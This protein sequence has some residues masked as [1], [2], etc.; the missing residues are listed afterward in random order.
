MGRKIDFL[1]LAFAFVIAFLLLL[2]LLSDGDEDQIINQASKFYGSLKRILQWSF[3]EKTVVGTVA[4][5][6]MYSANACCQNHCCDKYTET[7]CC[8]IYPQFLEE[9][10]S[11][12]S[13]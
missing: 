4:D 2:F 6:P 3:L 9:G 5:P 13:I 11:H 7:Y 10:Y 1:V 8:Q 12:S